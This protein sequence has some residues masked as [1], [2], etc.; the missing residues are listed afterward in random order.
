MAFVKAVKE[1]SKL[2]LALCSLAG[3]GKTFSSLS[4]GTAIGAMMRELK[5]GDG[6]VGLIDTEH[7]SAAKFGG[8]FDFD[9]AT[10]TSYSP[11]AYVEKI[12]EAE[13]AGYDVIIVD[14]LTHAWAGKGGALD[15]KDSAAAR[16]GNSWT[17]W[18]DV[19]PKH[20]ELIEAMLG[21]KAHLIATM[22]VKMEYVQ[23][24]GKIEKVGLG[25]VQREGMEYEF[26]LV[27]DLD[28]THSLRITKSRFDGVI[29]IGDQFEKPG[30]NVA[31]K[32]YGWLMDGVQAE[33]VAPQKGVTVTPADLSCL[34]AIDTS[35]SHENLNTL[36]PALKQLTGAVLEEARKRFDARWT[37]LQGA[38]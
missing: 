9:T 38:A 24:D 26:D 32:I 5:Q 13:Q 14:S 17:A 15:Q 35:P 36:I 10:L 29:G 12:H 3:Y 1:Q 4:I 22:R 7:R 8:R 30:E 25:V 31:R 18:R 16:S 28:Q 21:C 6:R 37:K 23:K 34:D 33:P 11:L 2:R 19:T 20:N 27:G